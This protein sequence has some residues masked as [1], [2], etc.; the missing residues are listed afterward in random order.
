MVEMATTADDDDG[1]DLPKICVVISHRKYL[2]APLPSCHETIRQ[3]RR[4]SEEHLNATRAERERWTIRLSACSNVALACSRGFSVLLAHAPGSSNTFANN[5]KRS[6]A[7]DS[8]LAKLDD[9]CRHAGVATDDM[10]AW[11]TR[12]APPTRADGCL[13]TG[14][15]GGVVLRSAHRTPEWCSLALLR[16]AADS[17]SDECD[18]VAV[19]APTVLLSKVLE[20]GS[21]FYE[22]TASNESRLWA[23][24]P[25]G[26]DTS[27]LLITST[28]VAA[29]ETLR[30][31]WCGHQN[32]SPLLF[33]LDRVSKGGLVQ[34]C[35]VSDE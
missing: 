9:V 32:G 31:W 28:S 20:R 2:S 8:R 7:L 30:D 21:Q 35:T 3:V 17:L 15:D 24:T 11:A 26:S 34:R 19:A 18:F 12:S 22:F 5:I 6:D 23:A 25:P 10:P 14:D 1:G 27:P 13:N 29:R 4:W 33:D 16:E